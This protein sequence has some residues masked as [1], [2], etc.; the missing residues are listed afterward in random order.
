MEH[1]HPIP[2]QPQGAPDSPARSRLDAA[3]AALDRSLAEVYAA[4]HALATERHEPPRSLALLDLLRDSMK[5]VLGRQAAAPASVGPDGS[6]PPAGVAPTTWRTERALAALW[7][8][9]KG[10]R[11]SPAAAVERLAAVDLDGVDPHVVQQ[12]YGE[13]LH[14]CA[15]L[16]LARPLK[17]HAAFGRGAVLVAVRGSNCLRVVSSIGLPGWQPGAAVDR[18]DL[19]GLRPL[20]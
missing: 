17:Y 12:V 18:R 3:L 1:P 13:W 7:D 10:L 8:V 19:P 9:R 2:G 11:R 16:G 14:Q 4:A 20:R 5:R 15:R 6:I